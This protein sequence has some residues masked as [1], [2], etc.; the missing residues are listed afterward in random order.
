MLFSKKKILYPV[1][2]F[3][4]NWKKRKI[5]FREWAKKKA[6]AQSSK[7]SFVK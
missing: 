2:L 1:N 5:Y 7:I 6:L 4:A 3:Q